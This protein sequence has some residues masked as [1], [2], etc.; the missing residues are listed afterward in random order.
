MK[1]KKK[2]CKRDNK[3][4]DFEIIS[5]G[6]RGGILKKWTEMGKVT[7]RNFFEDNTSDELVLNKKKIGFLNHEK[8]K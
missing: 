3:E 7:G 6:H 8:Q 4:D 5:K 2:L 1:K